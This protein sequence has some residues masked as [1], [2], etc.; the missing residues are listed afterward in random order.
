MIARPTAQELVT[1][2][3]EWLRGEAAGPPGGFARR[4]AA[5]ALAIVARELEQGAAADRR[6]AGRI[7]ALIGAG[8]GDP[9]HRLAAAIR[10]GALD[11][12]DPA[13]LDHLALS[14]LDTLAIDQPRYAHALERPA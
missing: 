2:V 9:Q 11:P 12:L 13:L 6:A 5:N 4:V 10:A 3:I 1:A 8:D 14:A 7:E